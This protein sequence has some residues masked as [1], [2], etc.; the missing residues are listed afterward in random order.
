MI[1]YLLIFILTAYIAF[2]QFKNKKK[3]S[4]KFFGTYVFALGVFVG[5]S[6]MLGGYDRY[7]YCDVFTTYV[8]EMSKGNGIFNDYFMLYSAKEPVCGFIFEAIG[9]LTPNRYIFI[10]LY[11]LIVYTIYGICFYRYTEKPFFAL[12]VFLGL[13]FFFTFTYLRQILAAGIIWLA[14]PY[15]THRKTWKYLTMIAIAAMVHNSGIIMAVLYFIPLR[16]WKFSQIIP[17][18][19]L[20]F[21]MGLVGVGDFMSFAGSMTGIENITE[22]AD[23]AEFGFRYEYVVESCLFLYLL[24]K[25]YKTV[26]TDKESLSYLNLYLL[27]CGILLLFCKSS[28]GGRIAWYGIMGIIIMLTRFCRSKK[29]AGLRL[30]LT[31][32]FFALYFRILSAWG[33]ALTPYKTCFTNGVREGDMVYK[34]Y[35]YDERYAEDKFYNLFPEEEKTDNIPYNFDY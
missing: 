5:I 26:D 2:I 23:A 10:L 17:A 35:E 20:L 14:L 21:G 6:D 19:I 8:D 9:L 22:H 13:M 33:V 30:F 29:S 18:M 11:T 32:M 3:A 24:Y 1:P 31:L 4:P 34:L 16:K 28:D 27:F 25:N 15:Y 7:I 12:L